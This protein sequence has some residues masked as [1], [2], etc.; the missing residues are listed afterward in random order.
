VA[1]ADSSPAD[2]DRVRRHARRP[3]DPS[4]RTSRLYA[5]TRRRSTA[6]APLRRSRHEIQAPA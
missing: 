4:A 3:A 1:A 5:S 6:P 2:G